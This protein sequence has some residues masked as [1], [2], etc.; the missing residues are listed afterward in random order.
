MQD[1]VLYGVFHL[2]RRSLRTLEAFPYQGVGLVEEQ[3]GGGA[4][5][6]QLLT[7][8]VEFR[9]DVFL[10]VSHPLAAHLA[11][12]HLPYSTSC[13]TR[14]LHHRLRLPGS[15]TPVK[16]TGETAPKPAPSQPLEY[17]LHLLLAE[18]QRQ[19][20][21][22]SCCAGVVIERPFHYRVWRNQVVLILTVQQIG[23]YLIRFDF[24]RFDFIR[25]EFLLG[26]LAQ[27]E[28][29]AILGVLSC[30]GFHEFVLYQAR[31]AGSEPTQQH[32]ACFAVA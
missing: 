29:I 20:L 21:H 24:I 9:L 13:A 25:F 15:G 16:K 11:V 26:F 27:C 23:K 10:A 31:R 30:G 8:V 14:Q 7:V 32:V 5:L 28:P 4:S 2:V 6:R 3:D 19:F 12:V 18:Q 22:L 17:A 1:D